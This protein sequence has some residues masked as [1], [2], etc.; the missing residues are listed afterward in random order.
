MINILTGI[1]S[2]SSALNAE[3]IRMDVVSQNI[4]NVNT[5]RGPNGKPYARQQVVFEAVLKDQ[6]KPSGAPGGEPQM[7]RVAHVE[8]ARR[9]VRL[10]YQPGHADADANGMVAVPNINIHEEMVDLM[11]ASR[12]YE[13]NL[14]VVKTARSMALQTLSIGKR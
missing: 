8:S 11:A 4:A 1:D 10:V 2:T 3:R 13:A 6:L 7:V 14:S 9:P 5:T 12:S